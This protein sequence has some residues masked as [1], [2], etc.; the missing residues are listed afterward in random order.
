ML[1]TADQLHEIRGIVHDYHQAF[2]V[3]TVSPGAVAP[4][5]L[6]RLKAKGLVS[7]QVASIEDAYL[8]GQIL[9]MMEDPKF[10]GMSYD[11]FK[12]HVQKNPIPL[13]D[14]EQQAIRFAELH[15]AQSV[16][17]LGNK[18]GATVGSALI[19]ADAKQRAELKEMIRTR[20]QENIAKRE[21]LKKLKSEMGWA[22][23]D[24]T[25]DLHR[26]A[27]TEKQNAMQRGVADHYSKRYGADVL[28]AKR[29]MPDA[30]KHC[31]RLH[32][33]PDGHPRIFKLS[34]LEA[35]GTNVGRKAADWLPVVGT[36]HP[37]CQ[38]QMIRVPA[39]WGF[40]E[41]GQLEPGARGGKVYEDEG[42]LKLAMLQEMDLQKAFQTMGS[43]TFQGLPITIENKVGSVRKWRDGEG[44]TGETLMLHAYGFIKRT[45][46][47]D[48]DELDCYIGPDPQATQAYIIHQQNPG[49][50]I[51]DEAKVMLGF[52]N[53][54]DARTAYNLHYNR[55]DFQVT[56]SGLDMDAF[57][58]WIQGTEPDKGEMMKAGRPTIAHV[59]PLED[60]QK[61]RI[62]KEE[63]TTAHSSPQSR[64]AP[65]PGTSVNYLFNIP[66]HEQAEPV[67]G[68]KEIL[69]NLGENVDAAVKRDPEVYNFMEPVPKVV[70]PIVLP[71][72]WPAGDVVGTG[73][74]EERREQHEKFWLQNRAPVQNT[75]DPEDQD[76][77]QDE[78]E[79]E[80][81]GTP[82]GG[83]TPKGYIKVAEGKYIKPGEHVPHGSKVTPHIEGGG[84][85]MLKVPAD[86]KATLEAIKAKYGLAGT[87]G[88]GSKYAMVEVTEQELDGL[89]V[90]EKEAKAKAA[91]KLKEQAAKEAPKPKSKPST[92]PK[93]K[94]LKADEI[95]R[96]GDLEVVHETALELPKVHEHL[97]QRGAEVM[98]QFGPTQKSGKFLGTDSGGRPIVEVDGER[99][100][101]IKKVKGTDKHGNPTTLRVPN[102]DAV[103]PV[104]KSGYK[105]T[106]VGMGEGAL[107][108]ADLRQRKLV[109]SVMGLK[110]VGKHAATEFADYLRGKGQEVYLVGGIVRDLVRGTRAGATDTDAEVRE[111]MKDIDIVTS[112]HP[113]MGKSMMRAVV[114][115]ELPKSGVTND[116]TEWGV[117]RSVGYGLGLDYSSMSSGGTYEVQE[118]NKDTKET[119][120]PCTWDHEMGEDAR[121]RDFTCNCLY[122]DTHND[123]IADP[124]GT[125]IADA[126]NGVLRLAPTPDEAM[127][128]NGIF[129]RFWKFRARGWKTEEKT[130]AFVRKHASYWLEAYQDTPTS[131]AK[132]LYGFVGKSGDPKANLKKLRDMMDADGCADLFDKY[133]AKNAKA[134]ID[135]AKAK[136]PES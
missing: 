22:S 135:H 58:R 54:L 3:N 37:H 46:G 47:D 41:E 11:Q 101:I 100:I 51:Y 85:Y 35:N 8:Y 95:Q 80:K 29:P 25:R 69:E 121:R 125:G 20:T 89:G 42:E 39:G 92:K 6:D 18:A 15:G 73:E 91:E 82:I 60:F 45:R 9:A 34:E 57:K 5:V 112:G 87:V 108:K 114:G 124:T 104:Q 119:K 56:C 74:T 133:V 65:S 76:Q 131:M 123:V 61:A 59:I 109:A 63:A 134:I 75:V 105:P 62:S 79:L 49:T 14:I 16:L 120:T 94:A 106:F 130:Q 55:D 24:W 83:K 103:K 1:L 28:V 107:V 36:V 99:R 81:G 116:A 84:K 7:V 33:G 111:R 78:D 113:Q 71:D 64:N 118:W 136:G 27:N 93:D 32:L 2:V 31:K 10:A 117:V 90:A 110:V 102:W 50:G 72:N 53:Q 97:I 128:N 23:R 4:D 132:M 38:C 96:I 77:D 48:E 19:E 13:N 122:Y 127:E 66:G 70:R 88:V 26:I 86:Q 129:V 67:E 98:V 17:G 44:G 30:C 68:I 52:S 43:M 40:N 115:N 12:R 126:Q 21:S